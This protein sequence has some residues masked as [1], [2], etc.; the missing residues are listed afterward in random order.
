MARFVETAVES[1][2][3]VA[4]VVNERFISLAKG[5]N[6]SVQHVAA[7]LSLQIDE[8]SHA[9]AGTCPDYSSDIDPLDLDSNY[10]IILDS[11]RRSRPEAYMLLVNEAMAW[12]DDIPQLVDQPA[13]MREISRRLVP[14]LYVDEIQSHED[15]MCSPA[16]ASAASTLLSSSKDQP[17]QD[18]SNKGLV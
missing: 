17:R 18:Q 15:V 9:Y 14:R 12:N 13:K 8:I 3:S 1:I 2:Q 4:S 10:V 11:L 7:A 16:I 5:M 6:T